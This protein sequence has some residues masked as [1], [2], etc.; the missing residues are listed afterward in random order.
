MIRWVNNKITKI[1]PLLMKKNFA[2]LLENNV[3]LFYQQKILCVME[4]D[5]NY[6]DDGSGI[7]N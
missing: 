1:I 4:L 6:L 2:I 7:R 5:L 3:L